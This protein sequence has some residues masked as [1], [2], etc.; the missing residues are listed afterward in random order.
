M[1]MTVVSNLGSMA[2]KRTL[3][4]NNSGFDAGLHLVDTLSCKVISVNKQGGLE[5]EIADGEPMVSLLPPVVLPFFLDDGSL[6]YHFRSIFHSI[7]DRRSP[8]K[9]LHLLLHD[10]TCLQA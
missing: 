8:V 1:T 2:T 4:V 10:W 6:L 5:I 7:Y 9:T 3:I